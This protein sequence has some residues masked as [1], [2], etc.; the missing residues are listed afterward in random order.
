MKLDPEDHKAIAEQVAALMRATAP[1]VRPLREAMRYC[2]LTSTRTFHKWARKNGLVSLRGA[3]G[4]YSV[5]S[6][7][8]AIERSSRRHG[9]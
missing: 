6:M 5:D 3:R 7:D 8:A 4:R 9:R 2:G 1:N